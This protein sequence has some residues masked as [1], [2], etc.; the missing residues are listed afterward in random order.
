[1]AA[2]SGRLCLISASGMIAGAALAASGGG[3]GGKDGPLQGQSQQPRPR[4]RREGGRANP[5][6][7]PGWSPG[8]FSRVPPLPRACSSVALRSRFDTA[9]GDVPPPH[10]H[11]LQHGHADSPPYPTRGGR[12]SNVLPHGTHRAPG[13]HHPPTAPPRSSLQRVPPH[14]YSSPVTAPARWSGAAGP[15]CTCCRPPRRQGMPLSPPP[16]PAAGPGSPPKTVPHGHSLKHV[17]P[18]AP[19]SCSPAGDTERSPRGGEG[20]GEEETHTPEHL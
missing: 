13:H 5:R 15:P 11:K 4:G 10:Q 9:A 20:R 12:R 1:M 16:P 7:Y 18:G 14:T 3:G 8:N 2:A 6:S 19:A 17:R